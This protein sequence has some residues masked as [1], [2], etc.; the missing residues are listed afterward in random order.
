M[1]K[2]IILQA[3]QT[4][5]E[6]VKANAIEHEQN[7]YEPAVAKL[8]AKIK[9]WF[10]TN[11]MPNIHDITIT[12]DSLVILPSDTTGYGTDITINHRRNWDSKNSYFEASSYRPDLDSREDNTIALHYYNTMASIAHKFSNIC[13]EY[14][15]KW[16]P[17][18]NKLSAAKTETYNGIYSLEREIRECE[19]ELAQMA[20][21]V[22]NQVG[23]ECTLKPYTDYSS[24]YSGTDAVY[25]K[26]VTDHHIRAM[27]GRARWDYYSI[28]SFKVLSFPKAKHG[29]VVLEY[30][31]ATDDRKHTAELNKTR[32]A[33]FINDVYDWQSRGAE[34]REASIDEKIARWN[35]V[36]A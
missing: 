9:A 21:E 34:A 24:D 32:Y 13:T 4:Q 15:T 31:S 26:K 18:Y 1:N 8:T 30:K 33:D 14:E 28:N 2:Q 3:L 19:N 35:K 16:L 17:V 36:E 25:T 5:L 22:Y 23:F 10:D 7:V 27:Y 29:K 11:V 6:T 12:S 20:K